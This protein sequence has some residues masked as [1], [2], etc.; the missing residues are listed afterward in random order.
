[1]AKEFL[2]GTPLVGLHTHVNHK[3]TE[4]NKM[5]ILK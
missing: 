2:L 1:M 5:N 3:G 4:R